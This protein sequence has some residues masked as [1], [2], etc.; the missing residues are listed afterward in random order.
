LEDK[1]IRLLE[2]I[3]L[4]EF[5]LE[6]KEN[7]NINDFIDNI[8]EN[9]NKEN[10][11]LLFFLFHNYLC[12][13]FDKLKNKDLIVNTFLEKLECFFIIARRNGLFLI[14]K[15][16]SVSI[17]NEIRNYMLNN[18]IPNTKSIITFLTEECNIT[19]NLMKNN[20]EYFFFHNK[21]LYRNT[22]N[23][24]LQTNEIDSFAED[25]FDNFYQSIKKKEKDVEKLKKMLWGKE[26]IIHDNCRKIKLLAEENKI[27]IHSEKSDNN[28]QKDGLLKHNLKIIEEL[29]KE[30]NFFEALDD[31]FNKQEIHNK[32]ITVEHQIQ[33]EIDYLNSQKLEFKLSVI[34]VTEKIRFLISQSKQISFDKT[35]KLL[36]RDISKFLDYTD[37]FV[38]N[39][40]EYNS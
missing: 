4:K 31:T 11:N 21:V 24:T 23:F 32:I 38:D 29:E 25:L 10:F 2:I 15:H 6:L 26:K 37:V 7:R 17:E 40:N 16:D 13:I 35:K 14:E 22:D 34:S 9:E 20:L 27:S 12:S 3:N 5:K 28:K 33:S 8:D 18:M 39:F 1:E 36:S 30:I 19:S